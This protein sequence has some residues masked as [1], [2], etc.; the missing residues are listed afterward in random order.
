MARK[1]DTLYTCARIARF[2]HYYTQFLEFS[3]FLEYHFN[4]LAEVFRDVLAQ[5]RVLVNSRTEMVP[6]L[7]SHSSPFLIYHRGT[8]HSVHAR[9]TGIT[10]QFSVDGQRGIQSRKIETAIVRLSRSR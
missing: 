9:I 7:A 2:A 3:D 5:I 1:I 4:Q 8:K 10:K 6:L